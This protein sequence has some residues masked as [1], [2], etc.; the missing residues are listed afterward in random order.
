MK[1]YDLN[2]KHTAIFNQLWMLDEDDQEDKLE[3]DRLTAELEN[4]TDSAESTAMFLIK[5]AKQYEYDSENKKDAANKILKRAK[6]AGNNSVKFKAM[7]LA[8]MQ[9]FDVPMVED[10]EVRIKRGYPGAAAVIVDDCVSVMDLPNG[11]ISATMKTHDKATIERALKDE[12]VVLEVVPIKSELKKLLPA[13]AEWTQGIGF[14]SAEIL[15][16]VYAVKTEKLRIS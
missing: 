6:T 1:I 11:C 10:A 5:L 14:Q 3:F 15:P 13:G 4:L 8:L 16:G 2:E 7:A 9:R 12:N